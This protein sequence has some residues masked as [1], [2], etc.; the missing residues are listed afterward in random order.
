MIQRG[1]LGV[2][3][4]CTYQSGLEGPV[5]QE[6]ACGP[7]QLSLENHTASL[8]PYSWSKE[9]YGVGVE[10]GEGMSLEIPLVNRKSI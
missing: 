9:S 10:N 1:D 8:L 2:F 7:I 3:R 6:M 4:L 5:S